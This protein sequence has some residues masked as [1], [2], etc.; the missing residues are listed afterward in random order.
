M[1]EDRKVFEIS[2]F[3]GNPA[4]LKNE[5]MIQKKKCVLHGFQEADD[6]PSTPS[7]H[8]CSVLR[9][10]KAIGTRIREKPK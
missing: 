1:L 8:H 3:L 9:V 4:W 7:L 5:D 6:A 2:P 10:V